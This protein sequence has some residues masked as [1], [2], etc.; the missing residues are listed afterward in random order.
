MELC[1]NLIR[2]D[3][4]SSNVEF[5][6]SSVTDFFTSSKLPQDL[7][8]GFELHCHLAQ[9]C[10][11]Y[12][13]LDCF[14]RHSGDGDQAEEYSYKRNEIS[15]PDLW[16]SLLVN[17]EEQ[18]DRI[19]HFRNGV[20][21]CE[22]VNLSIFSR[23]YSFFR[24]AS[25]Y[26]PVHVSLSSPDSEEGPHIEHQI[27]QLFRSTALETWI[28]ANAALEGRIKT[29]ANSITEVSRA[30]HNG[31]IGTDR[32]ARKEQ[33]KD[34]ERFLERRHRKHMPATLWQVGFFAQRLSMMLT[35]ESALT[36]HASDVKGTH[37]YFK[38]YDF[39]NQ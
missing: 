24:Y 31:Y 14:Q 5:I 29:L 30:F 21:K 22:I 33:F 2:I 18:P 4:R 1:R 25:L 35:L 19:F 6:H 36:S 16:S 26:W 32:W 9:G 3:E 28:M 23:A 34:F 12:L 20:A 7:N 27:T 39:R 38:P 13:M 17:E 15:M 11:T 37:P 8:P 10:S